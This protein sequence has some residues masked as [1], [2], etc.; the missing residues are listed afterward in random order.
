M[1]ESQ[2]RDGSQAHFED[3]GGEQ[4]SLLLVFQLP[5]V[6]RGKIFLDKKVK[7]ENKRSG[8]GEKAGRSLQFENGSYPRRN[9]E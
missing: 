2:I 9:A 1:R 3:A 7:A 5:S 6:Q 8:G 4:L